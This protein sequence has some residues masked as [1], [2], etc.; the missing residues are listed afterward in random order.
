M[1]LFTEIGFRSLNVGG[2]LLAILAIISAIWVIYDVLTYNRGLSSLAKL[3][4]IL[5]AIFFSIIT[6]IVY[7]FVYK[8]K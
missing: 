8:V 2:S 1:S 5:F 4:W 6:A 7:F 3:L